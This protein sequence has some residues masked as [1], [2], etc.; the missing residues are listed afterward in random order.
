VPNVQGSDKTLNRQFTYQIDV[1]TT[2]HADSVRLQKI[3]EDTM[4]SIRL[5]ALAGGFDEYFSETGR[6]VVAK[7]YRGAS[8]LYDIE[9]Y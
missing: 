1:E 5:F 6:Y 2:S 9:T 4:K 8:K 7:R 3:I